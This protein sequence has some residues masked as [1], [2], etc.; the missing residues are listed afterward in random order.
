MSFFDQKFQKKLF[1]DRNV[2]F[3][4]PKLAE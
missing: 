1:F 3:L 2:G 4:A